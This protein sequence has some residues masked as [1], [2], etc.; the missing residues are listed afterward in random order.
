MQ[1]PLTY[2]EKRGDREVKKSY[3]FDTG[4]ATPTV[5]EIP[6][7]LHDAATDTLFSGG[8]FFLPFENMDPA[9]I[10][11]VQSEDGNYVGIVIRAKEGKTFTYDPYYSAEDQQVTELQLGWWDHIQDRTLDRVLTLF[12]QVAG[13]MAEESKSP[14]N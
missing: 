1:L 7:K 11:K 10:Q 13:A 5:W 3:S 6:E 4:K 12:K 9:S 14:G 8:K 2:P